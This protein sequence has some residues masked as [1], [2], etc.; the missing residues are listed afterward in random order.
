M[1]QSRQKKIE[2]ETRRRGD[3]RRKNRLLSGKYLLL[4]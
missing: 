4:L 1:D 3:E 2:Q